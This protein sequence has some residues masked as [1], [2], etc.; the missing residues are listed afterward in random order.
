MRRQRDP[1][2]DVGFLLLGKK[3]TYLRK[4]M[5]GLFDDLGNVSSHFQGHRNCALG[6]G[7]PICSVALSGQAPKPR[8]GAPE[9]RGLTANARTEQ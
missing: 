7:S 5:L 3:S 9:A 2:V 4:H 1:T 8:S 6:Y